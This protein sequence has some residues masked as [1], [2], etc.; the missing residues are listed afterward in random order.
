MTLVKSVNSL[1]GTLPLRHAAPILRAGENY[2]KT[3]VQLDFPFAIP[4]PRV[5]R[6]H[7]MPT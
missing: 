1:I 7:I 6:L 5:T 3:T 4:P 2:Y